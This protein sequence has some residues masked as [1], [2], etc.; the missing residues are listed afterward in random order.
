M[1]QQQHSTSNPP[2]LVY[3]YRVSNTD[4]STVDDREKARPPSASVLYPTQGAR[5]GLVWF[6]LALFFFFCFFLHAW[7]KEPTTTDTGTCDTRFSLGF[8]FRGTTGRSPGSLVYEIILCGDGGR[9]GRA[10]K[11]Y[12]YR[13]N[14]NTTS[15]P[16]V[17]V[18]VSIVVICMKLGIVMLGLYLSYLSM[19]G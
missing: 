9:S 17:W 6:G 15:V 1:Q 16:S 8:F 12:I 5:A 10:K 14:C 7:K 18:F 11:I 2:R 3:Q 19:A 4:S 13:R